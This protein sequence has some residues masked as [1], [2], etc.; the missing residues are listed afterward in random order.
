MPDLSDR[1]NA[2]VA[3]L[4]RLQD[5]LAEKL[6]RLVSGDAVMDSRLN[7][8]LGTLALDQKTGQ[9]HGMKPTTVS[10]AAAKARLSELV[11][12]AARGEPVLITRHGKPASMLVS[13]ARMREPIDV[14]RLQALTRRLPVQPQ[15]A[16]EFV[17]QLRDEER[18]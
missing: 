3:R 6:G 18:Y 8:R 16:R 4:S 12:R 2:Y 11:E 10:L 17:R 7:Q 9:N 5:G 15:G 14:Q 1:I 13:A